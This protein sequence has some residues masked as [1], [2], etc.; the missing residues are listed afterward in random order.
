M[1]LCLWPVTFLYSFPQCQLGETGRLMEAEVRKRPSLHAAGERL[2]LSLSPWTVSLCYGEYSVY[3]TKITLPFFLPEPR[4]D[5]LGVSSWESSGV[6]GGKP[7]ETL[8]APKTVASKEFL[9][10]TLSLQQLSELSFKCSYL[11]MTLLASA[12]GQ[13][14][15]SVTLSRFGGGSLFCNFSSLMEPRKVDF[16]YA[17]LLLV[18]KMEI[19]ISRLFPC[20]S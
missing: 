1:D 8:C 16:P 11:F 17:Q 18:V 2:W 19:T 5:L 7:H 3:F 4:G 15:S 14:V 6:P 13:Q 10:F 20:Q 12:P 9:T